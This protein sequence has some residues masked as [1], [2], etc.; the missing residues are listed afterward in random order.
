VQ[1]LNYFREQDEPDKVMEWLRIIGETD[2]LSPLMIIDILKNTNSPLKFRYIKEYMMTEVKKLDS[3]IKESKEEIRSNMEDINK[4]KED[5]KSLVS[6]PRLFEN[7]TCNKCNER[8]TV[9]TFHFMCG[10]VYHEACVEE[11]NYKRVCKDCYPELKE[12]IKTKKIYED[13]SKDSQ[14]F[15]TELQDGDKKMKTIAHYYGVGLFDEIQEEFQKN[16]I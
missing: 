9:P 15:F 12:T 6:T 5:H 2:A 16:E 11:D 8:L 13:K 14:Q 4:M 1:A 3:S 10:H 7:S